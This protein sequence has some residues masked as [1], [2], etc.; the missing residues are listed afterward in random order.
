[1]RGDFGCRDDAISYASRQRNLS[2]H[3]DFYAQSCIQI[4]EQK[5][6]EMLVRTSE[7]LKKLETKQHNM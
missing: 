4:N 6:A 5:V 2:I 1:M 7:M 3:A